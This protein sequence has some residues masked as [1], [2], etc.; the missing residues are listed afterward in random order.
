MTPNPLLGGEMAG[1]GVASIACK[2]MVSI[3]DEK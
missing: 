3:G 1:D 2:V